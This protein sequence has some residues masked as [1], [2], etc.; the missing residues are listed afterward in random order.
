M[1]TRVELRIRRR[2]Y[3]SKRIQSVADVSCGIQKRVQRSSFGGHRSPRSPK[4]E[5][6][7]KCQLGVG[8]GRRS[9]AVYV[10]PPGGVL[11]HRHQGVE[12]GRLQRVPPSL[13]LWR[14]RRDNTRGK[15][16]SSGRTGH[17]GARPNGILG[18]LCGSD[19][20]SSSLNSEEN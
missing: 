17:F 9:A 6:P 7:P 13:Q 20:V 12:E 10:Q 3:N 18:E 16:T 15:K 14:G 1:C 2:A 4:S 5:V 8:P 19:W 11:L